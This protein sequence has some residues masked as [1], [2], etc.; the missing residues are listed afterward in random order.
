[1]NDIETIKTTA[2]RVANT[3][4]HCWKAT[5]A[6]K[7]LGEWYDWHPDNHEDFGIRLDYV[8]STTGRREKEARS[9]YTR[10]KHTKGDAAYLAAVHGVVTARATTIEE[11][12]QSLHRTLV[13]ACEALNRRQEDML[14]IVRH[15]MF[16][17]GSLIK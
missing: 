15:N 9:R 3:A 12:E 7:M 11:A 1:M 4:R 6:A 8:L 17:E 13:Y 10:G 14:E 16:R 2:R 5:E